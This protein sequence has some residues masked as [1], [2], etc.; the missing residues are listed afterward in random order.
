MVNYTNSYTNPYQ[1]QPQ[2]QVQQQ[3]GQSVFINVQDEQTARNWPVGPGNSLTF[4]DEN[5][6]YIYTKTMVSQ[7]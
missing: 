1:P 4:K 7:F 5:L 3:Q 2:P 6:P